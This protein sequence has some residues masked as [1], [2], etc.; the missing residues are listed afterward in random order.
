MHLAVVR[1]KTWKTFALHIVLHFSNCQLP[2][3]RKRESNREMRGRK[4]ETNWAGDTNM[5]FPSA[6]LVLL[7]R[8]SKNSQVSFAKLQL[9]PWKMRLK[10][11]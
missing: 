6:V 11:E 5:Y 2:A 7:L 9:Q 4:R 10:F 8:S 1:K 3:R